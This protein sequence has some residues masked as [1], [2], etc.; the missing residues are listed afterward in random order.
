MMHQGL[1]VG[2]LGSSQGLVD[3][4]RGC[5]VR[6]TLNIKEEWNIHTVSMILMMFGDVWLSMSICVFPSFSVR[7]GDVDEQT[8]KESGE[9]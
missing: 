6:N 1:L 2:A 7:S 5:K 3:T 9:T 8:R 4:G